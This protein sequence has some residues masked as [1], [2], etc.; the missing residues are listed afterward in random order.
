MNK[1]YLFNSICQIFKDDEKV[2]T[3]VKN[4]DYDYLYLTLMDYYD[5]TKSISNED[6]L[7]SLRLKDL[8]NVHG[9]KRDIDSL[10]KKAER[11]IQIQSICK[12]YFAFYNDK[13]NSDE[14]EWFFS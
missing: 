12:L 4:K 7:K 9:L 13:F 3:F 1:E 8:E 10:F 6:V 11:N 2:L 14:R 5:K